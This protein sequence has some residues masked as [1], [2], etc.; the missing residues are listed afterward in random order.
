MS[1]SLLYLPSRTA[2]ARRNF[3]FDITSCNSEISAAANTIASRIDLEDGSTSRLDHRTV[4]LNGTSSIL[5]FGGASTFRPTVRYSAST[6]GDRR[7]FTR[8]SGYR[9]TDLLGDITLLNLVYNASACSEP[10]PRS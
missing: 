8:S 9:G 10:E 6:S 4:D 1:P 7:R 3:T 5:V 2:R